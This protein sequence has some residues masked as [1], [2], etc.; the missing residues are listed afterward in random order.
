MNT[1]S[2]R[3]AYTKANDI[4]LPSAYNSIAHDQLSED[5][6]KLDYKVDLILKITAAEKSAGITEIRDALRVNNY[7]LSFY[8]TANS[9]LYYKENI[10]KSDR[11]YVKSQFSI[12]KSEEQYLTTMLEK[13]LNNIRIEV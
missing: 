6:D 2:L 12:A 13:K 1:I 5:E 4:K 7:L 10:G 3:E 8:N 9:N 11:E